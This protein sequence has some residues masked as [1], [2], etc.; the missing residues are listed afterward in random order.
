VKWRNA[1][2]AHQVTIWKGALNTF[3]LGFDDE[4]DKYKVRRLE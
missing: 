1:P 2:G 4:T 3:N